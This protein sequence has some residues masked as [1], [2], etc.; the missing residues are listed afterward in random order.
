VRTR[1]RRRA[2]S[3]GVLLLAWQ[4]ALH[5]KKRNTRAARTYKSAELKAWTAAKLVAAAEAAEHGPDG[6][7]AGTSRLFAQLAKAG[8]DVAAAFGDSTDNESPM[9]AI[10]LGAGLAD[11][12]GGGLGPDLSGK[13]KWRLIVDR[14]QGFVRRTNMV[15][16]PLAVCIGQERTAQV[17]AQS[18]LCEHG[19]LARCRCAVRASCCKAAFAAA[20]AASTVQT[21][22]SHA[23]SPT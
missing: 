3:G 8:V 15:R 9:H 23:R 7:A 4:R 21:T 6:A 18:N 1:G 19:L 11:Q 2:A 17:H 13:C 20:T 22:P 12:L 10:K 16:A 14:F 5:S